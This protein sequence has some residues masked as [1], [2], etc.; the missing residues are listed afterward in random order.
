[1]YDTTD[2][3]FFYY[4]E[5]SPNLYICWCK[6][7]NKGICIEASIGKKIVRCAMRKYQKM[8][9]FQ[10]S[11]AFLL[12]LLFGR[13]YFIKLI[14]IK[15]YGHKT[16]RITALTIILRPW[17][18]AGEYNGWSIT[19]QNC[20]CRIWIPC[21]AIHFLKLAQLLRDFERWLISS[22]G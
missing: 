15:H 16:W 9:I 11:S 1:M 14:S 5:K 18:V 20:R 8:V 22:V 6:F 19:P 12:S 3:M 4:S 13:Y 17:H 21:T 2:Q 10:T 7:I